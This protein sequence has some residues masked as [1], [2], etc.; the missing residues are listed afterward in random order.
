MPDSQDTILDTQDLSPN[1]LSTVR[2]ARPPRVSF[3][4]ESV[5]RAVPPDSQELILASQQ[6]VA[7]TRAP[8]AARAPTEELEND[9]AAINAR[10][11]TFPKKDGG[12]KAK[13]VRGSEV[14]TKERH[15]R[16]G[17]VIDP[18]PSKD[19]NSR[20]KWWLV[21][22]HEDGS[23]SA[24]TSNALCVE[25][26]NLS[27]LPQT[28]RPNHSP[29]PRNPRAKE[30]IDDHDDVHSESTESGSDT[31]GDGD[32]PLFPEEEEQPIRFTTFNPETQKAITY[33]QKWLQAQFAMEKLIGHKFTIYSPASAPEKDKVVWRVK[34]IHNPSQRWIP[35]RPHDVGLKDF[36]WSVGTEYTPLARL[37]CFFMFP[38]LH[39]LVTRYNKT[40]WEY[41]QKASRPFPY[42]DMHFILTCFTCLIASTCYGIKGERLWRSSSHLLPEDFHGFVPHPEFDRYMPLYKFQQFKKYVCLCRLFVL[43]I[44]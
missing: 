6:F 10:F 31:D 19:P 21:E 15:K 40:V 20:A 33:K 37:F 25:S 32:E 17:T 8:T 39:G 30:W 28:F 42:V 27:F 22:W 3:S 18:L 43:L 7:A 9:P 38:D 44:Y 4:A 14:F 12:G 35:E 29:L 13:I 16:Y 36:R 41:N 2:G 26:T 11:V 24:M 1:L 23:E 34:A 5:A